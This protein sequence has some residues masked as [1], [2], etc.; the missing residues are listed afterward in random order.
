MRPLPIVRGPQGG[1]KKGGGGRIVVW[2]KIAGVGARPWWKHFGGAL[3][4]ALGKSPIWPSGHL[5]SFPSATNKFIK[6][7][8]K[9]VSRLTPRNLD[10]SSTLPFESGIAMFSAEDLAKRCEEDSC[11]IVQRSAKLDNGHFQIIRWSSHRTACLPG[12]R[13]GTDSLHLGITAMFWCSRQWALQPIPIHQAFVEH[14]IV[15]SPTP[16]SEDVPQPAEVV[17]H[18]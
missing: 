3:G 7:C 4:G 15:L 10:G 9:V 13:T 14:A 2:L 18:G 1:G 6:G 17:Q 8:L 12:S 11:K 5:D 16:R